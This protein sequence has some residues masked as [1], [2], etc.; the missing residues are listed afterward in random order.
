MS[1]VGLWAYMIETGT[2]L[3][4][5]YTHHST[6]VRS[7]VVFPLLLG[8][9]SYFGLVKKQSGGRTGFQKA[10]SATHGVGRLRFMVFSGGGMLLSPGLVAWTSIGVPRTLARL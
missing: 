6:L 10:L 8:T 9:L 4:Y 2:R 1:L 5:L 7:F 3:P